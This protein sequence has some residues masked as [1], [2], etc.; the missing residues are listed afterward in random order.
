MREQ[1][2]SA[3]YL[4]YF[5]KPGPDVVCVR[6]RDPPLLT[7][8][9]KSCRCMVGRA[10]SRNASNVWRVEV[11]VMAALPPPACSAS[12]A[13][14]FNERDA[15]GPALH[16]KP[17]SP[18]KFVVWLEMHQHGVLQICDPLWTI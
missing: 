10:I 16:D 12:A 6:S 3:E 11:D 4:C 14:P 17:I 7:G 18:V 9:V 15:G 13:A 8:L 1:P 2:L 5:C